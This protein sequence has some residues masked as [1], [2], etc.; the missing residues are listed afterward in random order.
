MS[1]DELCREPSEPD[2][3]CPVAPRPSLWKEQ[4]KRS[5]CHQTGLPCHSALNACPA[6][7]RRGSNCGPAR[8]SLVFRWVL[9]A[10]VGLASAAC[11]SGFAQCEGIELETPVNQID[12][13]PSNGTGLPQALKG[14]VSD[15]LCCRGCGSSD[16]CRCTTDCSQ[17][18]FQDGE[19]LELPGS[20]ETFEGYPEL[21]NEYSIYQI[22][23]FQGRVKAVWWD[24]M[25]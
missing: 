16:P 11:R 7:R 9:L 13:A 3:S 5:D 8:L 24:P 12:T 10:G 21:S 20:M 15:V 4:W 23:A 22:W 2:G 1:N 6:H 17:P 18:L 14:P 19:M 25:Y